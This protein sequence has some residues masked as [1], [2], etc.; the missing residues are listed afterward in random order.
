MKILQKFIKPDWNNSIL[1]I[2]ATL[3]EYLGAP[4]S[5]ATLPILK[6][7]LAKYYKNIVYICFDGMGINPLERNLPEDDFLRQHVAQTLTSTFPSTTTNATTCLCTNKLPLEHGW[8][9]WSLHFDELGRNIDIYLNKDSQTGEQ[10]TF[11]SPLADDCDGYFYH[12]SRTDYQI[13]TIYPKYIACK[14]ELNTVVENVEDFF[15]ALHCV[16]KEPG[17]HFVYAYCPEPDGTMHDNGVTCPETRAL[18]RQIS[19]GMKDLAANAE[20]TL[21]IVSADHGQV[22]VEGYIDW[23]GETELNDMLE[24]PPYLDSRSPC[25]RVKKGMKR[26]FAKRF[27]E[28]YGKDFVLFSTKY[29]IEHNYFGNRGNYGY[30]LGDFIASG[31]YTNKMF[32]LPKENPHYHKGHHTA[33]TKEMLVPMILIDSN[34]L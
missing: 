2:S 4:N 17:K 28:K 26:K 8:L 12:A 10:V 19:D 13:R 5:N 23:R 27:R 24:C 30:L 20:D 14:Q 21:F 7:K 11:E 29:L 16:C 1:N 31:T 32:I 3:A 6:Q 22:D 25:F 34:E 9:G 33:L 18:L 15:A